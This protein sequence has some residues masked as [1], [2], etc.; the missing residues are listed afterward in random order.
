MKVEER[1]SLSIQ[2]FQ[3][4]FA[5]KMTLMFR[6]NFSSLQDVLRKLQSIKQIGTDLLL[7][8]ISEAIS[9]GSIQVYSIC[10]D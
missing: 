10:F 9:L 7:M 1:L 5:A 4:A 6:V 2:P 8:T 3:R